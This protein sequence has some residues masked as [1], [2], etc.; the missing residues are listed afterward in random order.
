MS[1][2]RKRGHNSTPE[3]LRQKA[4]WLMARAT[5]MELE[6][7]Q[8]P[9]T[10]CPKCGH[11]FRMTGNDKCAQSEFHSTVKGSVERKQRLNVSAQ[12]W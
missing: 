4:G 10:P 9:G 2:K 7:D 3:S 5:A 6:F 11:N 1:T 12:K 8:Y